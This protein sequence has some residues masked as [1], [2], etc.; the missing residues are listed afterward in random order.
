[1]WEELDGASKAFPRA[2]GI[3]VQVCVLS[4]VAAARVVFDRLGLAVC[5]GLYMLEEAVAL[6]E[7]VEDALLPFVCRCQRGRGIQERGCPPS[8][9]LPPISRSSIP[10]SFLR[11]SMC[12][13]SSLS[14]SR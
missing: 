14:I 1:M 2:F 12:L 8:C 11:Q 4:V 13:G 10:P 3:S 6:G 7:V 5:L 9:C